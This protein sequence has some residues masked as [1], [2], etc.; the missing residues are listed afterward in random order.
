MS[1]PIGAA[2]EAATGLDNG[3]D[4]RADEDQLQPL[5]GTAEVAGPS[6]SPLEAFLTAQMQFVRA[7]TVFIHDTTKLAMMAS[8]QEAY[9][10]ALQDFLHNLG[11]F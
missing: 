10:Y 8:A 1:T 2:A 9:I 11:A 3:G 7:Q 4:S 5:P 6:P